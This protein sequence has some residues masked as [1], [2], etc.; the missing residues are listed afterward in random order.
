MSGV[1]DSKLTKS[2]I[3][4]KIPIKPDEEEDKTYAFDFAFTLN[5]SSGLFFVPVGKTTNVTMT[6]PWDTPSFDGAFLPDQRD[7]AKGFSASWNVFNYNRDFPQWWTGSNYQLQDSKFGVNLLFP[8]DHYQKSMRSAKYAIMFIALTF[9]A[10]FMVEL[11]SRKPIHPLQYLLASIGLVLF[12]T[13][14]L[15]LSEQIHFNLAYLL[16]AFGIISLITAYSHSIFKALKQTALMGAF[17]TMLYLFLFSVLQMEDLALLFGS[18]GLFIALATVMYISR[19]VD[20]YNMQK[21]N[22]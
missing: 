4:V 22:T 13:L 9:L 5:G 15:S 2:G 19:K 18:L 6:S 7:I 10:F 17:L 3:T 21:P 11:I 1:N 16:S 20:W 12:Y 8:V 14:L